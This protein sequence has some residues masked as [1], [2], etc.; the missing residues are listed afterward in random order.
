MLKRSLALLLGSLAISVAAEDNATEKNAG[1]WFPQGKL[2]QEAKS[3]ANAVQSPVIRGNYPTFV[4]NFAPTDLSDPSA[5]IEFWIKVDTDDPD[6]RFQLRLY[7]AEGDGWY[8]YHLQNTRQSTP[9]PWKKASFVIAK[10]AKSRQPVSLKKI[11]KIMLVGDHVIGKSR[12]TTFTIDGL[13]LK[14]GDKEIALAPGLGVEEKATESFGAWTPRAKYLPSELE[15]GKQM[16]S[17]GKININYPTFTLRIPETDLSDKNLKLVFF[18]RVD[19]NH[20]HWNLQVRF[21]NQLNNGFVYYDFGKVSGNMPWGRFEVPVRFLRSYKNCDLTKIIK[22]MF[23]GNGLYNKKRPFPQTEFF[24]DGL[25]LERNGKLIPLSDKDIRA[26]FPKTP[27]AVK[28]PSLLYRR[29]DIERAKENIKKHEWA[30]K[31]YEEAIKSSAKFWID[32]P[33]DQVAA[34]VPDEGGFHPTC[35]KCGLSDTFLVDE[36]CT[37][38]TCRECKIDFPSADYPENSSYEFVTPTGKTRKFYCYLGQEQVIHKE[39]IGRRNHISMMLN[40]YKLDKIRRNLY[41]LALLYVLDGNPEYARKVRHVL[42]R[43]AEVYPDYVPKFRATAYQYGE[44]LMAGKM[45]SWKIH[46]SSLMTKLA[47]AYD[48]TADSGAYSDEDKVKIENGLFREYKLLILSTTPEFGDATRNGTPA[49]LIASTYI[50]LLLNDREFMEI[51]LKSE[52]GLNGFIRGYFKRDGSS[53]ESS[54]AYNNM[55]V[56]PFIGL[57]TALNNSSFKPDLPELKEIF[58]SVSRTTVPTGFCLP[59]GDSD[60]ATKYVISHAEV[61]YRSF[62]T[63]ENRALLNMSYTNKKNY[64]WHESL[65]FRDPDVQVDPEMAYP[66]FIRESIVLPGREVAMLRFGGKPNTLPT[67]ALAMYHN[68]RFPH[69]HH[70]SLNLTYFKYNTEILTD[71]GY[72]SYPHKWTPFLTSILAHNTVMVDRQGMTWGRVPQLGLFSGKLPVKAVSAEI[73]N[74]FPGV[75]VYRRTSV[76]VN[77]SDDNSF[78]V[79]SFRVDGGKEHSYMIHGAGALSVPDGG[80][81]DIAPLEVAAADAGSKYIFAAQKREIT[82]DFN[83]SWQVTSQITAKVYF[84]NNEKSEL[85]K[86]DVPGLRNRAT[87]TLDI[88]MYPVILRRKAA[89]SHFV[90]VIDTYKGKSSITSARKLSCGKKNV[91]VVEVVSGE[92]TDVVIIDNSGSPDPVTFDYHGKAVSFSGKTGVITLKNGKVARLW[93]SGSKLLSCGDKKLAGDAEIS[94]IITGIDLQKKS[95][96]TSVTGSVPFNCNDEYMLIPGVRD[97]AYRIKSVGND[98][99]FTLYDDEVIRLAVGNKFVVSGT[100]CQDFN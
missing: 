88:R 86:L 82:G 23:V 65:F 6:W 70:D 95:I 41:N 50:A 56:N 14:T 98:G 33:E 24:V 16:V 40:Y 53:A 46:D 37:K 48:L 69:G 29:E 89:A 81:S 11:N 68:G 25:Y 83:C 17:S 31:L 19:T 97:G 28:H 74:V 91:A 90:S 55:S 1:F 3:G 30:R 4:Y 77:H 58:R 59:I 15:I 78:V 9:M 39:S 18:A 7:S 12:Q 36:M 71:L 22:I 61:N 27:A 44:N 66:W 79:D 67:T 92:F 87:P 38:L 13:T 96:A 10:G 94:G 76:M 51:I 85:L 21:L 84:F 80:F 32:M 42:V 64:A 2:V 45:Y 72:L 73:N 8:T 62:P 35:P 75:S 60:E 63:E 100:Y 52:K 93:M 57:F 43:L 54:S 34:W 5:V 26:D 47:V 99:V 49:H 20:P